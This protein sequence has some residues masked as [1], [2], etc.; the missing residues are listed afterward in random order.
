MYVCLCKAL[1]ESDVQQIG[2]ILGKPDAG[3]LIDALGL[4]DKGCCGRCARNIEELVAIATGSLVCDFS[5]GSSDK[6][7]Y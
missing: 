5:Q 6:K 2:R 7:P 3:S 4:N 1:T